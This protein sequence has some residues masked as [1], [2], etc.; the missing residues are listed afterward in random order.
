MSFGFDPDGFWNKTPRVIALI[1]AGKQALFTREY[2]ERAL[3]A[4]QIAYFPRSKRPVPLRQMMARDRERKPQS[5]EQM[6]AIAK[7][8]TQ[9]M[10][11]AIKSKET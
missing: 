3:M 2:N 4:W 8:W 10:G 1:C 5:P 11:G 6:L 9:L 7:Q